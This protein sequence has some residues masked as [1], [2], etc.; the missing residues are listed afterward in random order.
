MQT[1]PPDRR[2]GRAKRTLGWA[3]RVVLLLTVVSC[4]AIAGMIACVTIWRANLADIR[5]QV[6]DPNSSVVVVFFN[7]DVAATLP[8][9]EAGLA[10]A[11]QLGIETVFLVGGARQW[12][13]QFGSVALANLLSDRALAA[14][15]DLVADRLSYDTISNLDRIAEFHLERGPD[16]A[17]VFIS[18]DYHLLRIAILIRDDRRFAAPIVFAPNNGPRGPAAHLERAIWE[19]GAWMSLAMPERIRQRWLRATR[20]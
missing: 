10:V 1:T 11:E 20:R 13:N 17:M 12:R 19:I 6:T 7:D 15:I 14:G 18:D 16:T 9:A 4:L 3:T 2:K 5:T 8:R